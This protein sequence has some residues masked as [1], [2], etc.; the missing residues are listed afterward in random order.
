[1]R[2]G[3]NAVSSNDVDKPLHCKES[4]SYLAILKFIWKIN[5]CFRCDLVQKKALKILCWGT[6]QIASTKS[7]NPFLV[8]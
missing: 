5:K 8:I 7:Q 2:L 3:E 6:K 4:I 1:M